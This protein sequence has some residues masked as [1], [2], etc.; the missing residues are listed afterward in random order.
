MAN[1]DDWVTIR[2]TLTGGV[3]KVHKQSLPVWMEKEVF[4]LVEDEDDSLA[5]DEDD[6]EPETT[7]YTSTTWSSTAEDETASVD[8]EN[9]GE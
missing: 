2:N 5:E 8:D 1:S 3:S 7:V 9:S 6:S 4:E